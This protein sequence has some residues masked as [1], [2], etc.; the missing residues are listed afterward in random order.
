MPRIG[1]VFTDVRGSG[2]TMRVSFHAEQGAAV[3]SLWVGA[4]CR[5]TF[6]MAAADVTRLMSIL[7]EIALLVDPAETT[8]PPTGSTPEGA[9]RGSPAG[10]V[11][12]ASDQ[13]EP[14]FDQTGEI[15]GPAHMSLLHSAPPVLGVA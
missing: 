9:G 12:A 8:R 14:P 2:R 4:M 11:A 1:D 13:S 3:V 15:A 7:S 6:R 10:A 5:G